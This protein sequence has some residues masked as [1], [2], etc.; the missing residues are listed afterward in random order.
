MIPFAFALMLLMGLAASAALFS[1]PGPDEPDE[2]D[3]PGGQHLIGTNGDDLL[4]GGPGDDLIEGRDGND[5]LDAQAGGMNTVIGGAGDDLIIGGDNDIL[6]G[7]TGNDTIVAFDN[8]LINGGEGDDLLGAFGSGNIV[9]GGEGDD[10]IL[11]GNGIENRAYGGPGDD[12]IVLEDSGAQATVWGGEGD[13]TLVGNGALSFI[14]R[15]DG[16]TDIL[17][18][19][20]RGEEG[21]DLIILG[22]NDQ[23]FGGPGNDRLESYD[24][25]TG[26][27]RTFG[28][29]F[30][31]G[32]PGDDLLSGKLG[33]TMTGGIGNDQ[34]SLL[35]PLGN[36]DAPPA[37]ITDFNPLTD[38]LMVTFEVETDSGGVFPYVIEQRDTEDGLELVVDDR[39]VLILNGIT[40]A[41]AIDIAYA[42]R[43]F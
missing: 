17:T 39:V 26:D 16:T 35:V 12:L 32:G 40:T 7:G 31:H 8:N 5:T 2:T 33:D 43:S 4:I 11:I 29:S 38:D 6:R 37:I 41:D 1:D 9:L 27:G 28:G 25:A 23:G 24:L 21:D 14:E 30:M 3:P 22:P 13:D 36:P 19:V 10:Q 42:E 34:F 18:N 15:P 20:L